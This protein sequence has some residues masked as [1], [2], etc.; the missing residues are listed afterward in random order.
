[1]PG[2]VTLSACTDAASAVTRGVVTL[3]RRVVAFV[4]TVAFWTAA[5]LPLVYVPAVAVGHV[6]VAGPWGVLEVVGVY[7][8]SLVVGHGYRAE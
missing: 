7:L 2:N 4:R 6:A 8:A 5:L 3:G 1:M